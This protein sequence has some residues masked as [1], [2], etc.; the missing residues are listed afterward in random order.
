MSLTP[1]LDSTE[2]NVTTLQSNVATLQ[3]NSLT[4]SSPLNSA[5]LTGNIDANRMKV[6]LNASGSAPIYACRAWVNFDGTGAS[7]ANLTIRAS[8][9]ISSVFKNS[10]GIYTV[11][12]TTA[13]P[14]TNYCPVTAQDHTF[15][16]QDIKVWN[17]STTA[18]GVTS[19]N[20]SNGGL[21]DVYANYV[22]FFR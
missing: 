17:S 10:T 11:N 8:G 3:S 4:A 16:N 13:M 19:Y 18:C 6:G 22:A 20:G 7:S 15:L 14:D 2:A 1:R 12:F 21:V 5:N 9:N